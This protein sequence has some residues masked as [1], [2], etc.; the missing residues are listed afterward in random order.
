MMLP[1]SALETGPPQ[2]QQLSFGAT[3]G[4]NSP[5]RSQ[6]YDSFEWEIKRPLI[7]HLYIDLN[8]P[9]DQVMTIMSQEHDFHATYVSRNS[10]LKHVNNTS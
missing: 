10:I 8:T 4:Q 9:L 6:Q 1:S 3:A 2:Q 7:K 5:R